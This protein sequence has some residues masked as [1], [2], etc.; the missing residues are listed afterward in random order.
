[1]GIFLTPKPSFP[2]LGGFLTP[3]QGGRNRKKR[4]SQKGIHTQT[5]FPYSLVSVFLQ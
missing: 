5:M 4:Y 3:V 2:D 1:M